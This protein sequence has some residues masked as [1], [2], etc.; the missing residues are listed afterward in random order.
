[1]AVVARSEVA[2]AVRIRPMAAEDR[3]GVLDLY[4]T[5]FGATA[6]DRYAERWS[7]SFDE[8]FLADRGRSW[9]L[10]DGEKIVGFLAAFA[11]QYRIDGH[12]AIAYSTGDYMVHPGYRFHGIK[13]MKEYFR[14]CDN[15]VTCDDMEATI[16]VSQWLGAKSAGQLVRYSGVLDARL[17]LTRARIPR[18]LSPAV[19]LGTSGLRLTRKLRSLGAGSG[20]PVESLEDFDERF[21]ML[22]SKTSSV[23]PAMIARTSAFLRWRFGPRSPHAKREIG[24]V[25]DARGQLTGYVIFCSGGAETPT[26]YILDLQVCPLADEGAAVALMHFAI[27]RLTRQGAWV[28]RYHQ[29]RSRLSPLSEPALRRLGLRARGSH[30]MLVRFADKRMDEI[31]AQASNWSYAYADSEASFSAA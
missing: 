7:W 9:V 5:V 4:A 12:D 30:L 20:T 26:G 8:G 29:L 3:E 1:M 31:A 21:D 24:I 11:F 23:A 19:G 22:A 6:A 28:V 13:L 27:D 18:F 25:E 2:R 10:A 17:M 14:A 16:A 15:T